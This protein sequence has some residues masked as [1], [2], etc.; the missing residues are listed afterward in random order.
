MVGTSGSAFERWPPN[1]AS[2]RALPA[3]TWDRQADTDETSTCELLP[4]K[5][6]NAGPPPWVGKWR[7]F[8]PAALVNRAVGMWSAPYSPDELKMISLGRFLASSTNSCS[9]LYGC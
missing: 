4:S 3:L 2:G 7:S 5:A 8:T 1:K 6:V 9:V